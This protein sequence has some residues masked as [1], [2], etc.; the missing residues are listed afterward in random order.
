MD[1]QPILTCTMW[2]RT[3]LTSAADDFGTALVTSRFRPIYA[4]N[5]LA[6]GVLFL[7]LG[8]DGLAT[9]WVVPE[10]EGSLIRGALVVL[11]GIGLAGTVQG[12]HRLLRPL[13]LVEATE[14][15][16]VLHRQPGAPGGG[17]GAAARVL[18]PWS[19]IREL[20]YE[21]HALPTGIRRSRAECIAVRLVDEEGPGVP[22]GFSH[23][24]APLPGTD[25][26]AVYIDAGSGVPGG[27][28]LLERLREVRR[29]A[30][31]RQG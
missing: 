25:P 4:A 10:N 26:G 29:E 13:I 28:D 7:L 8:F 15:G 20:D 21:V 1:T 23:L 12:V 3:A 30:S 17:V 9:N 2:V 16:L 22:E 31:A 11:V 24:L 6:T 27:R 19:R 14:K 5:I 18:V